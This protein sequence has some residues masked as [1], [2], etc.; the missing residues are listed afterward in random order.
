[1]N[2]GEAAKG[3]KE[4]AGDQGKDT[5]GPGLG[6]FGNVEGLGDIG[7]DNVEARDEEFLSRLVSGAKG[8]E[9]GKGNPRP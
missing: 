6:T 9:S 5:G 1:M 2:V 4:G 3:E 8:N 7:K